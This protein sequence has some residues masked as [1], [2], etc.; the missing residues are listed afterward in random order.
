MAAREIYTDNWKDFMGFWREIADLLG[1]SIV[2][3]FDHFAYRKGDAAVHD[4]IFRDRWLG[5][6]GLRE[7]KEVCMKAHFNVPAIR[8]YALYLGVKL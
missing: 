7:T 6:L 2:G 1:M 8:D 3:F 5:Q 4:Y